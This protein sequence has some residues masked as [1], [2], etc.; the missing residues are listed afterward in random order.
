MQPDTTP[1]AAALAL[2]RA[3]GTEPAGARADEHQV[4]RADA[5][6]CDGKGND[7]RGLSTYDAVPA[8]SVVFEL[9]MDLAITPT[10][11]SAELPEM[12]HK[13]AEL[14][15]QPGAA[16]MDA[17]ELAELQLAL[18]LMH[19]ILQ[20]NGKASQ[21]WKPWLRS[22]PH[23]VHTIFEWRESEVAALGSS[24]VV[25]EAKVLLTH[26]RRVYDTLVEPLAATSAG[27]YLP[28]ASFPKFLWAIQI[29]RSRAFFPP[30]TKKQR[31]DRNVAAREAVTAD[32][33]LIMPILDLMNHGENGATAFRDPSGFF[34]TPARGD[35][36][37][38]RA[39]TMS[40]GALESSRLQ[41][42]TKHGLA[43]NAYLHMKYGE[44]GQS[45]M[46]LRYGFS[47]DQ[48]ME[49]AHDRFPTVIELL[50][51]PNGKTCAFKNYSLW[52]KGLGQKPRVTL[53]RG[54][55]NGPMLQF[56]RVE[57]IARNSKP[58]KPGLGASE[59]AKEKYNLE[60]ISPTGPPTLNR[61]G[62]KQYD[63]WMDE[64]INMGHERRALKQYCG[65]LND[66]MRQHGAVN[67]AVYT[68]FAK[69]QEQRN[70]E[71]RV[72]LLSS[73]LSNA[74]TSFFPKLAKPATQRPKPME[75]VNL[76]S[77]AEVRRA[78]RETAAQLQAAKLV[79]DA[80]SSTRT[81]DLD[82]AVAGDCTK[83]SSIHNLAVAQNIIRSELGVLDEQFKLGNALDEWLYLFDRDTDQPRD[84]A[85]PHLYTVSPRASHRRAVTALKYLHESLLPLLTDVVKEESID[86]E[87]MM[88]G[89]CPPDPPGK[90]PNTV[91]GCK[92]LFGLGI[93]RGGPMRG[94]SFALQDMSFAAYNASRNK[95]L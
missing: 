56:S 3:S 67:M 46:L 69:R 61:P 29:A 66:T 95:E 13:L 68:L 37:E 59:T 52:I 12:Y 26:F 41:V 94:K 82:G 39:R 21:V 15:H 34:S 87:V 42:W 55:I 51:E 19:M 43:P 76:H 9:P 6:C 88:C 58:R 30:L 50:P 20:P 72:G 27:H 33:L 2:E 64:S 77:D 31:S 60:L 1:A 75:F 25:Q 36:S 62:G 54:E 17:V 23:M 48:H 22:L 70:E 45:D 71:K 65:H 44:F 10:V 57:A 16:K 4:H 49:S 35:F 32:A 53:R 80:W 92:R 93:E 83:E 90:G 78:A 40:L 11:A 84:W 63:P 14:S 74:T 8:C 86:E 38:V 24:P 5:K 89:D 79:A 81:Y 91:C 47:F 28:G 73:N 85:E 18:F 7:L